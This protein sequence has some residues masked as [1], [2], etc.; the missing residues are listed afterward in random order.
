MT[1]LIDIQVPPPPPPP[2]A[3]HAEM[4]YIIH[5]HALTIIYNQKPTKCTNYIIQSISSSL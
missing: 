3:V 4:F 1:T 2:P 5:L